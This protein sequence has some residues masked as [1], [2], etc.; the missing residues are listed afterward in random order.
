MLKTSLYGG[1]WK[2]IIMIKFYSFKIYTRFS[3]GQLIVT[4]CQWTTSFAKRSPIRD[5]LL[6]DFAMDTLGLGLLDNNK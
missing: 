5:S 3:W 2:K 6:P 1:L 4:Y